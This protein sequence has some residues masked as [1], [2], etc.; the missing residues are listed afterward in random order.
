MKKKLL[1]DLAAFILLIVCMEYNFTGSLGHEIIGVVLFIAL[2]VHVS[3]NRKYY[4]TLLSGKM[5]LNSAKTTAMCLLNILLLVSL[6]VMIITSVVISKELLPALG[7]ATNHY[8]VWRFL[9]VLSACTLLSTSFIHALMHIPMFKKLKQQ[10]IKGK[11]KLTA[12]SIGFYILCSITGVY[13][14]KNNIHHLSKNGSSQ[15]I[16]PI[17]NIE[18]TGVEEVPAV[19]ESIVSPE[20]NDDLAGTSD[21][22]PTK[23]TPSLETYL[24]QL[25]C[26]G[27]GKHCCLLTPQCG[28]GRREAQNATEEYKKLY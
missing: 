9:H 24:G 11:G 20:K 10:M 27:C 18:G 22:T 8:A 7:V 5:K 1:L 25:F 15:N 28:R 13:L 21:I 12:A 4:M 6:A 19:S 16:T 14:V 17:Q 3:L 23:D 26:Q 2:A